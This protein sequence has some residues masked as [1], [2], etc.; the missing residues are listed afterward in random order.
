MNEKTLL[1]IAF[2][3]SLAGLF[4]LFLLSENIDYS[5]KTIEKIN[6]ER[7]QDMIKLNGQVVSVNEI[8]NITFISVMQPNYIDVIVFEDN[9]SI[10]SGDNVEIIGKGEEYQGEMELIA[11]RIRVI[12]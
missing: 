4:A 10:F 7:I 11:H 6:A 12:G 9:I 3:G 1:L 8:S 5:E 2:L